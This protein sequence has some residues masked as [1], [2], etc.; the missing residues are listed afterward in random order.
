MSFRSR[1]EGEIIGGPPAFAGRAFADGIHV[2]PTDSPVASTREPHRPPSIDLTTHAS[3]ARTHRWRSPRRDESSRCQVDRS[4]GTGVRGR[5]LR[6]SDRH[7]VPPIHVFARQTHGARAARTCF[8][9]SLSRSPASA[10]SDSPGS[11]NRS[12]TC[13]TLP[14]GSDGRR[15][16]VAAGGPPALRLGLR[17]KGARRTGTRSAKSSLAHSRGIRTAERIECARPPS[18]EQRR[19]F[20]LTAVISS[21]WRERLVHEYGH[22]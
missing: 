11:A 7:E 20:N 8:L 3:R 16:P 6:R 10:C 15:R 21:E 13:V 9:E 4:A 22:R 5:P 19:G 14:N 18:C 17:V 1:D 12:S 2:L